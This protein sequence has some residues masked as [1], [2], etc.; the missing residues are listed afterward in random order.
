MED[1]VTAYQ[2][3]KT[4]TKGRVGIIRL[5]R[6]KALNALCAERLGE[7][8]DRKSASQAYMLPTPTR[9]F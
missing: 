2:N 3:I 7:I 1:N 8:P 4:E 5:D 9:V 6:P